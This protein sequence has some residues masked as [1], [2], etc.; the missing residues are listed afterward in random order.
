[1]IPAKM[2]TM[3]TDYL[4]SFPGHHAYIVA[5]GAALPGLGE[6]ISKN[7]PEFCCLYSGSINEEMAAVAPYL[8]KAQEGSALLDWLL[9]NW[10]QN[11]GIAA[12]IPEQLSFDEVKKHFHS[13]LMIKHPEGRAL[14]FR[15]YDPRVL[16]RFLP[17][18]TPEQ[19]PLLF[20]QIKLFVM[21]GEEPTLV[22]RYW[23]EGDQVQN[24]ESKFEAA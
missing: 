11:F 23:I 15:Y 14:Y 22:T 12:I 7:N 1:M 9:D 21:E 13:L 10:G 3:L 2:K 17:M 5:D 4:F 24:Q 18:S 20:D 16:R 19:M 8:I 6:A